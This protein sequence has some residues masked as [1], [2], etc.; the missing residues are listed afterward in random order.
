[1]PWGTRG[2]RIAFAV[3]LSPEQRQ[4]LERMARAHCLRAGV[5][6]QAEIVLMSADGLENKE[7]ARQISMTPGKAVGIS[8]ATVRRIWRAHGLKPHLGRTFELSRDPRFQG[9]LEDIVSL[10]LNPPEHPMVLCADEKSRIQAGSVDI[11]SVHGR[12][13][14]R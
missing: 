4:A 10:Y 5:V 8:E 6:E 9:K 12:R 11:F 13:R 14:K 7:I 2:M 3:I 1:M